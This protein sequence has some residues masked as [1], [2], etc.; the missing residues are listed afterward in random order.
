M[1]TAAWFTIAMKRENGTLVPGRA[2]VNTYN[3]VPFISFKME[4]N[5]SYW[6]YL[7][8]FPT[9]GEYNK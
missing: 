2:Y 7:G 9:L 6:D 1:D 4:H 5:Y 3:Y 8:R